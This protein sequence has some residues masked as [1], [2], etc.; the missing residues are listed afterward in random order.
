M[1]TNYSIGEQTA[2]SIFL[3]KYVLI[4]NIMGDTRWA[5]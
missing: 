3:L 5:I 4:Y 1:D 2:I